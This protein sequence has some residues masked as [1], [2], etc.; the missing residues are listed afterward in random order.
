MLHTITKLLQIS[1]PVSALS[2]R[3]ARH[4]DPPFVT[5]EEQPAF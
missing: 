5:Q 2:D 4:Y 1:S 3:N